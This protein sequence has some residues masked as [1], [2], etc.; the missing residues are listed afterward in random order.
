M[1]RCLAILLVAVLLI[2]LMPLTGA[3]AATEYATVVGG[4]LRL[5]E[6]ASFNATTISSYKTGTTVKVLSISNGWY[7]VETPDGRTGYMYGQYLQ[8][9]SSMTPVPNTNAT[10]VSGNGYG[11]RMRSGPSTTYAVLRK[12][13]VGTRAIILAEGQNWCRISVGGNVG[14]MMSQFLRK[15]GSPA[16]SY[17]GDATVWAANGKGV[18]L[19]TGPSTNYS[20]IG[21]YSVGTQVKILERLNGWYRIQIGSRVGYMMSQFLIENSSYKVNGVTINNLKPVVGNILAVQS[22][23]PS[24]AAITYQWLRTDLTGKESV[25]GTNA[26]YAVTDQ[27]VGCTFRLRVDGYG[28]WTGYAVSAYTAAVTNRQQLVG[29]KFNH[30]TPVVGDR[31]EPIVEPKDATYTCLW[32]VDGVNVSTNS[33]YEV[34]VTAVGKTIKLT[35]TGTGAYNGSSL[36][37]IE[38]QKVATA[39]AVTSASIT[40]L[41]TKDATPNVGDRLQAVYAPASASV[42][43]T[44]YLVD[45]SG[46]TTVISNAQTI[47]VGSG[48]VG[49]A[50]RLVV[51]GTGSY[52]GSQQVVNTGKVTNIAN[53]TGVTIEG[54]S[55]PV[56]NANPTTLQAKVQPKEAEATALT[57]QWLRDKA[58]IPG[59]TGATYTVTA[60]DQ[61][62]AISVVVK[63]QSSNT[64]FRG[65]AT[66]AE[67]QKVVVEP[68]SIACTGH[69]GL[70]QDVNASITLAVKSGSAVNWNVTIT[71][72]NPGLTINGNTIT[73]KPN[74]S[75]TYTVEAT[76]TNAAGSSYNSFTMNIA[77]QPSEVPVVQPMTSGIFEKGAAVNV[78]FTASNGPLTGWKFTGTIPE[79]L[80]FDPNTGVLNGATSAVGSYTI[81]VYAQNKNGWSAEMVYAFEV[82]DN[83][84]PVQPLTLTGSNMEVNSGE[85]FTKNVLQANGGVTPYS[86][87]YTKEGE[88]ID[89][90]INSSTGEFTSNGITVEKET[91]YELTVKVTDG[92]GNAADTKLTLTVKPVTKEASKTS[93]E[94]SDPA[95]APAAQDDRSLVEEEPAEKAA[96]EENPVVAPMLKKPENVKLALK[97]DG[98]W[99][100]KWDA[101]EN[102]AGYRLVKANTD[103]KPSELEKPQYKFSKEPVA[104]V[105]YEIWAIA[106]DG[107]EGEHVVFEITEKLL[108]ELL[109]AQ[110]TEELPDAQNSGN[111]Q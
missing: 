53:L 109:A 5:R 4:W 89:M 38:S 78:Q 49:K 75:G 73:G 35:I 48:C 80:K 47:E 17:D 37:T 14:Y 2:G 44:W 12:W 50:I 93:E 55:Q 36:A 65:E 57:Y 91:V 63:A 8:P 45:D 68:G 77:P 67:T 41:T 51:E 111:N 26:S 66:S 24:N 62:K 42:K 18:R 88:K 56:V 23:D 110:E 87:E 71:P 34:P 74:A 43:L 98:T 97:K 85:A 6:K 105:E 79:G 29:V 25:V 20:I 102:A 30:D 101:I 9:T 46:N 1:K 95:S 52:T 3:L 15:D 108:N 81:Q 31:L 107:S 33:Y 82:K 22:V 104:G 61:D 70:M 72:G 19:R 7:R 59:A 96:V 83:T 106:A 32:Q 11:V 16:P 94:T 99:L 21:V 39:G 60:D 86:Y 40:N 58:E 100:L 13:P 90:N 54:A 76:A 92:K 84:V 64:S 28:R 103:N 27:D 69:E 10:V